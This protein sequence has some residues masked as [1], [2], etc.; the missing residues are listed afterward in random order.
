MTGRDSSQTSIEATCISYAAT[1]AHPYFMSD[2]FL[3]SATQSK[4]L[5]PCEDVLK[6]T[7]VSRLPSHSFAPRRL[8]RRAMTLP[9]APR[10]PS[11]AYSAIRSS[12]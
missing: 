12:T 11:T 10:L 7:Y 6:C 2:M 4:S 1:N 8:S 5:Y 3:L 9:P